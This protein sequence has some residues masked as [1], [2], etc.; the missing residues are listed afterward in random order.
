MNIQAIQTFLT[1]V[2]MRN[3]NRAAE[4]L[5]ITQ[6]AVTAR[7]DSLDRALGAELLN[8]SRKGAT[9]TKAGYAFID[10]AEVIV[11]AWSGARAQAN[12]PQGVT[13]LFSFVCAPALWPGLGQRWIEE[14]RV[15]HTETATEVWAGLAEDARRWLQSGLSDAAL[16]SEPMIGPEVESRLFASDKLVQYSTQ[17][18]EVMR[19][20]PG[21]VFVDYGPD[22]RSWHAEVWPGDETASMA[23]STPDWAFSYLAKHGGSA[24]LPE[25][26]VSDLSATTTLYPVGGAVDFTRR[27]FLSWRKASERSFPWLAPQVS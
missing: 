2:R 23:F 5:N 8:R 16:L 26:M 25:Q 27:S 20:D 7:L 3:L 13:R 1:V 4:E 11:S 21:Y 6:S 22:F 9:L 19:W 10:R 12:L 15:G 14:V 17:P 18:R 24:Y